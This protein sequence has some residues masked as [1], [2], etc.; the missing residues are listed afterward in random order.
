[1]KYHHHHQSGNFGL[2]VWGG[3]SRSTESV[4]WKIVWA[5]A[6]YRPTKPRQK[7]KVFK[8]GEKLARPSFPMP[9]NSKKHDEAQQKQEV[10][11]STIQH[12]HCHKISFHCKLNKV[13]LTVGSPGHLTDQRRVGNYCMLLSFVFVGRNHSVR[14]FSQSLITAISHWFLFIPSL[15]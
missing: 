11:S 10:H 4:G 5:R 14:R 7:W 9:E 6:H 13:R 8:G 3:G 15:Q 1:M 12:R 2:E